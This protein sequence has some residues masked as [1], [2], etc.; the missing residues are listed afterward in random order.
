MAFASTLSTK[1]ARAF[2]IGG[3]L[4]GEIHTW[5]AASADVSGTITAKNLH[6]VYA[7]FV[8]GIQHTTAPTFSGKTVTLAFADP[9]ATVYGTLLL[10]GV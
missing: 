9:A 1:E 4:K 8:D 10:V 6:E 3:P 5:T 7:V 2:S